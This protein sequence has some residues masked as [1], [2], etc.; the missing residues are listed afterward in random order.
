[1]LMTLKFTF[2][3][4]AITTHGPDK[5][6]NNIMIITMIIMLTHSHITQCNEHDMFLVL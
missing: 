1:M 5:N 2:K 6:S 4:K 3:T